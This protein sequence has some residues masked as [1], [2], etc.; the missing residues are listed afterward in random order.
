MTQCADAST[1]RPAART[2][3][4]D[5]L[6]EHPRPHDPGPDAVRA[7]AAELTDAAR[8]LSTLPSSPAAAALA[9]ALANGGRA[10]SSR[11]GTEAR[12]AAAVVDA[13]A[14][15]YWCRTAWHPAGSCAFGPMV[16]GR[17]AL[18]LD[19]AHELAGH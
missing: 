6:V 7:V 11:T 14:A 15:V 16:A 17:C 8:G 13:A 4:T 10:A 12:F 9:T 18:V 1:V 19:A 5:F 2:R 3:P